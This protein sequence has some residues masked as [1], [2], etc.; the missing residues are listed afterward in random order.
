MQSLDES[1]YHPT[2]LETGGI[3]LV[4][5]TSASCGTCRVVERRLPVAAPTGSHLFKV[6]V[7]Q[8]TGLARAFEIFHLPT[9]LLY[10]DGHFHA[11]LAC[12][13]SAPALQAELARALAGPAE[14]EP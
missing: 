14:E 8:A 12:E 11:R 1:R 13:I 7:Q 10:R 9:L 3:A 5:F 2:L 6:D 4:L